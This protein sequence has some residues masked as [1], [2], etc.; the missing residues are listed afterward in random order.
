MGDN[1]QGIITLEAGWNQQIKIEALDP[2]EV[3]P[4][5]NL[6]NFTPM[7]FNWLTTTF[8][9]FSAANVGGWFERQHQTFQQPAICQSLH[10]RIQFV[11]DHPSTISEP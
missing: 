10:V 2:L 5:C 1:G 3:T 8:A 6:W 11:L 9:L 4:S 7:I